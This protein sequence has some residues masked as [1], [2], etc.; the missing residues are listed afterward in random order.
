MSD[1]DTFDITIDRHNDKFIGYLRTEYG[2]IICAQGDC[3]DEV[4]NGLLD[5]LEHDC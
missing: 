3:E 1:V 5:G 4:V 2:I